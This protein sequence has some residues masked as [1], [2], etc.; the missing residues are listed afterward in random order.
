MQECIHFKEN[1][2]EHIVLVHSYC[3]NF[4]QMLFKRTQLKLN[5]RRQNLVS[6]TCNVCFGQK[7]TENN[8][9]QNTTQKTKD[10]ATR[11]LLQTGGE[12]RSGTHRVTLATNPVIN[13]E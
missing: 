6:I 7:K 13:H 3:Y 5:L 2:E 9:L 10:R 8:D 12:L 11:T 4:Q 1:F